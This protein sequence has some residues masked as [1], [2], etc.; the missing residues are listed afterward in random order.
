MLDSLDLGILTQRIASQNTVIRMLEQREQVLSNKLLSENVQ[1]LHDMDSSHLSGRIELESSTKRQQ[2]LQLQLDEALADLKDLRLKNSQ[3]ERESVDRSTAQFL[4]ACDIVDV[5]RS[6]SGG[7]DSSPNSSGE[8]AID[9]GGKNHV[10][11]PRGELESTQR[12]L[13]ERTVQLRIANDTMKALQ[14]VGPGG[15]VQDH[16]TRDSTVAG[17]VPGTSS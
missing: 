6:P 5:A 15:D 4:Q 2:L 17:H 14:E 10:D 11:T 9:S 7:I 16:A 3:L 12:L 13:K 8:I 1:Q